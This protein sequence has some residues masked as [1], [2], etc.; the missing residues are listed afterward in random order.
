MKYNK[1]NKTY[2]KETTSSPY[3]KGKYNKE[4]YDAF[5]DFIKDIVKFDKSKIVL[6]INN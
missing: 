2:H 1:N 4:E 6:K 5:R 3:N